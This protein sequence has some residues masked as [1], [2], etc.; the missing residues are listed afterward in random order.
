V[1]KKRLLLIL[2]A[3]LVCALAIPIVVARRSS[4][5]RIR[6]LEAAGMPVTPLQLDVWY[7]QVPAEENAA[8]ILWAAQKLYHPPAHRADPGSQNNFPE[9]DEPI[10][11]K[12][13]KLISDDVAANDASLEKLFTLRADSPSR[14]PIDLSLGAETLLPHLAHIITFAKLLRFNAVEKCEETNREA[15]VRSVLTGFALARTLRDEPILISE[16]IREASVWI[17]VQGL[18]RVV[19]TFQLD[20]PQLQ[21]LDHA[22]ATAEEDGSRGLWRALVG[23]R[24]LDLAAFAY[25]Y[26]QLE[27]YGMMPA[28]QSGGMLDFT[29]VLAFNLRGASGLRNADQMVFLDSMQDMI[30]AATNRFPEMLKACE[31]A[32]NGIQNRLTNGVGELCVIS[33]MFLPALEK[34]AVNAASN[35]A[36]V[37]CARVALAVEQY[38]LNHSGRLPDKLRDLATAPASELLDPFDANPFQYARLRPKGYR[39]ESRTSRSDALKR[40]NSKPE[41]P[42]GFMVVR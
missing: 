29:K 7:K 6:K 22:L 39:I 40:K 17:T 9:A 32:K 8:S 34:T 31:I 23:E 21:D 12:L 42:I 13:I 18:E 2:A 36:E 33:R 35:V 27:R 41:R 38:R 11:P 20:G 16:R 30:N 19:S 25:S 37:R 28:S 15:A 5:K 10:P 24:A 4:E 3:L 14:Y 26:A 1:K